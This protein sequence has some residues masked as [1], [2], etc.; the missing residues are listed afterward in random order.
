MVEQVIKE[1]HLIGHALQEVRAEAGL[2]REIDGREKTA[3]RLRILWE[4]RQ[5][6]LR[7]AVVGL[8]ISLLIA[9]LIPKRYQSTT[10]LMPPDQANSSMAM[11]A[12]AASGQAGSSLGSVASD[13]LGMKSSGALFIG[14]L[15]SRTVQEDLINKFALRNIYGDRQFE[16]ARKDLSDYTN[17]SEDRKS[18]IITVQVTDKVPQRAA[19]MAEEYVETLNRVVTEVNTSS[20][21]RERMF[22]EERLVQVKGDLESAEK[23]FSQFASKNTAIDIQEQGKA[24]I[25]AAGTLE[26]EL[27]AAE[28]ERQGLKQIYSDDNVRVRSTQ[29]R[30]EELERQLQRIGGKFDTPSGASPSNDKAESSAKSMYPSIRQLPLLG[31]S[32]ADLYRATKVQEAIFETLTREYE[33][34]KV[35]E[36]KEIPSV[37]MIDP[38][39]VPE[40]KSYPPRLQIVFVGTALATVMGAMWVFATALWEK[41][42]PQDPQKVLAL[43]VYRAAKD[44]FAWAPASVL[45]MRS[46]SRRIRTLFHRG[47]LDRAK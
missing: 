23:G 17:I 31:V 15:Q 21:H 32:Y 30:V 25:E 7:L 5:L 33:L 26:G 16:D 19:A 24:M 11:L 22:L 40:R 9:F 20:A 2:A 37:K 35:Q 29:A 41:T 46:A 47:E 27:I 42:D 1:D 6:I 14:I 45:G 44:Q 28:T 18:G 13:L 10:R 39:D 3:A 36:A 38:P 34:A 8:G 4:Q 43:E 12:V